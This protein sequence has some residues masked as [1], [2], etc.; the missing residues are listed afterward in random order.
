MQQ[1]MKMQQIRYSGRRCRDVTAT[2]DTAANGTG[3]DEMATEDEANEKAV[4]E[5]HQ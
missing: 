4:D 1:Q 2:E 3:E 5:I